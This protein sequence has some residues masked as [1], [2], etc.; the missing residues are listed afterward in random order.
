MPSLG[1]PELLMLIVFFAVPVYLVLL[2]VRF[3][4]AK[5]R[6][7]E[8]QARLARRQADRLP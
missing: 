6:A 7:A 8:E 5:T 1:F 2:L 4:K 3:L